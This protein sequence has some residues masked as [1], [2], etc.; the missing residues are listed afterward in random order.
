[1]KAERISRP[2]SVRI[3]MFCRLGSLE[4]SRP[5][6]ATTWL[7]ERVNAARLGVDHRRQ[8]VDV[9][10]FELRV[11]AVLDDL[12]RQRVGLGQLFQDVGI[13][14]R[15]GFGFLDDRQAEFLEQDLGQLFGRADVER[16]AGEL[17]DFLFQVA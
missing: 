6:A 10:A 11:L 17:F 12:C 14:A 1:M 9:R 16:V 3:G 2:S 5:V 13:G 4:L 15:A 8:R 7:N